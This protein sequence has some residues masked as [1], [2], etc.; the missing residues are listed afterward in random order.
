M[1]FPYLVNSHLQIQNPIHLISMSTT[2]L[3]SF[4]VDLSKNKLFQCVSILLTGTSTRFELVCSSC[5]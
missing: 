3:E 4:G 2:Y 5:S 1:I